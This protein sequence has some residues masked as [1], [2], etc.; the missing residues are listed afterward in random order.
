MAIVIAIANLSCFCSSFLSLS[1]LSSSNVYYFFLYVV[2]LCIV[3]FFYEVGLSVYVLLLIWRINVTI[4]R[5]ACMAVV[6]ICA[7][8]EPWGSVRASQRFFP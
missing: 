1:V 4:V 7:F 3:L 2:V 8:V 5:E 6:F